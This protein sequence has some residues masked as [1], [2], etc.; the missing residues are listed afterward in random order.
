MFSYTVPVP[1]RPVRPA[2][3]GRGHLPVD[4]GARRW[5]RRPARLRPRVR[6]RPW[7]PRWRWRSGGAWLPPRWH[8]R[9]P[10]ARPM[11]TSQRQS[12]SL[13]MP[14]L[15]ALA[16][17]RTWRAVERSTE[18]TFGA[19]VVVTASAASSRR[20]AA[21]SR[22]PSTASSRRGAAHSCA[23]DRVSRRAGP[24][25]GVFR[26]AHPRALN[27]LADSLDRGRSRL[28]ACRDGLRGGVFCA[29]ADRGHPAG[30]AVGL[31]KG[32]CKPPERNPVTTDF[33]S[34]LGSI[35]RRYRYGDD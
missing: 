1:R 12:S 11:P 2:T 29:R 10:P 27:A 13:R 31:D 24:L 21:H 18:E 25:R 20:G 35:I 9:R 6:R 33:P 28:L 30:G 5:S 4:L 34:G 14:V 17:G 15:P 3:A 7:P 26:P 8:R 19:T 16:S 23:L 32:H 22:A